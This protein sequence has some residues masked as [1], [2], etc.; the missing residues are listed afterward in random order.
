MVKFEESVYKTACCSINFDWSITQDLGFPRNFHVFMRIASHREHAACESFTYNYQLSHAIGCDLWICVRCACVARKMLVKK[1]LRLNSC[2]IS[3][4]LSSTAESRF[5]EF[6][7]HCCPI[8]PN[9]PKY[10]K[11]RCIAQNTIK[12]CNYRRRKMHTNGNKCSDEKEII[13]QS[14]RNA[15][16]CNFFSENRKRFAKSQCAL[17]F[18]DCWIESARHISG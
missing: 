15:L 13:M 1:L 11:Q 4:D 12:Q 8:N 17:R 6:H 10:V 5:A 14:S 9:M 7:W 3:R 16:R 18:Y 2:A